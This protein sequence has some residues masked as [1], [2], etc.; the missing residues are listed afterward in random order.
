M[1]LQM[2]CLF[3]ILTSILFLRGGKLHE[4]LVLETESVFRKAGFKTRQ[5]H[6]RRLPDGRLDFIDLMAECGDFIICVE[7]ETTARYVVTNAKKA[8]EL[9]LPLIVVV[10]NRQVQ[11]AVRNKLRKLKI[12]PNKNRIYILLLNQLQQHVTNCFSLFS[13][14]NEQRENKKI[15]QKKGG[16]YED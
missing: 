1:T 10:P 14:A 9:G 8:E 12:K 3:V 7:I 11:K 5:E 6:P 16:K 15:K 2:F 4:Y 13:L